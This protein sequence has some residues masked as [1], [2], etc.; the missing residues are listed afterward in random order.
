[1]I[2]VEKAGPHQRHRL[3]VVEDE[4]L[5]LIDTADFLR[6]RGFEVH[7]ATNADD[8]IRVLKSGIPISLV[9]TDIRMP[10][11]LDGYG[12]ANYIRAHHPHTLL[13][14]TSGHVRIDDCPPGFP[15]PIAKPYSLERITNEIEALL[16]SRSTGSANDQ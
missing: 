9:F 2:P 10:G 8:A 6:S 4:V 1:M 13:L 7:E 15:L 12:L 14:A 11:S 3:L 5:I 16:A